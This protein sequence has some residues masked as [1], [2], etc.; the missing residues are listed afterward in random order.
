MLVIA[1]PVGA[2]VTTL[3]C[4]LSLPDSADVTSGPLVAWCQTELLKA[5]LGVENSESILFLK[6]PHS[7]FTCAL[8]TSRLNLDG[9]NSGNL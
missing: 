2:D 1:A 6:T 3:K 9:V 5:M 4:R 8:L 7:E